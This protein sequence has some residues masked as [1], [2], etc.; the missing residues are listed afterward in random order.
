MPAARKPAV[1]PNFARR[2]PAARPP[3]NRLEHVFDLIELAF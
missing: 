3:R 2:R 1:F